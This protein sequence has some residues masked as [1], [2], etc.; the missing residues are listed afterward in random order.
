MLPVPEE[1]TSERSLGS[2]SVAVDHDYIENE[3]NL[4]LV[5]A[6]RSVYRENL[7]GSLAYY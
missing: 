3:V 5:T 7:Y 1:T 6:I 4:T 2:T